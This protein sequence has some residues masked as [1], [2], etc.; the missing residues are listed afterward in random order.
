MSEEQEAQTEV[1]AEEKQEVKTE[2]KPESNT[3]SKKP[4]GWDHVEIPDEV[5]PRFNRLYGE[6]KTLQRI[7]R[8]KDDILRQQSEAIEDLRKNQTQVVSYLQDTDFVKTESQLKEQRKEAYEKGNLLLVDDINDKLAEI[9]IEKKLSKLNKVNEQKEAPRG[10]DANKAVERANLSPEDMEVYKA[11]ANETDDNGN[12]VR[13]WVNERD[14]RNIAAATEGA[15]VFRN[16]IYANRA[17]G[18]KLKEID[19]R[20]GLINQNTASGVM[21]T[22]NL[23]SS[24]KSSTLKLTPNQEKIALKTQFAGRGKKPE[25][26]LAAYKKQ[27]EDIRGSK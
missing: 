24:K 22:G 6:V 20:M 16:P 18:D 5:K 27:L 10:F 11:W 19:K 17:F 15:A 4:E 2:T 7:S 8:E 21:G 26:H 25:E 12:L 9:K 13:P 14:Q 23:T 1:K 3:E